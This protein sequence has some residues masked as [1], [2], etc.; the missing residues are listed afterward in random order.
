MDFVVPGDYLD[1][2]NLLHVTADEMC[3]QATA[4]WLMQFVADGGR[5]VVEMP[6]AC[7]DANTWVSAARP[8]H[9]LGLLLGCTEVERIQSRHSSADTV[10]FDDGTQIT[11]S[12]W[13]VELQPT[14]GQVLATWGDG[15]AAVVLNRYS[16]G[17][18]L[19]CGINLSM[20]S[21]EQP[22]DPAIRTMHRLIREHL[23]VTIGA[24]DLPAGVWVRRRMGEGR[25]V[26]F[27]FNLT[28]DE[29]HVDLPCDP[30]DIWQS[31]GCSLN[32]GCLSMAPQASWVARM[33]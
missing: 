19:T 20:A 25:E 14:D 29:Q 23:G 17:Q 9:G 12:H 28:N 13:K 2:G 5:L 11:A 26:W 27:V 32:G 18:V 7:R 16:K 4:D 31:G 8:N 3:D 6:F 30:A 24:V 10:T 33:R 22:D 1:S 21:G 15:S